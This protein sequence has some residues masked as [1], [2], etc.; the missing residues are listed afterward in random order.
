MDAERNVAVLDLVEITRRVCGID[1]YSSLVELL[2]ESNKKKRR[3]VFSETDDGRLLIRAAKEKDVVIPGAD[4][5]ASMVRDTKWNPVPLYDED[6]GRRSSQQV[7]GEFCEG[8]CR[9]E[10]CWKSLLRG[11]C[12]TATEFFLKMIF[13]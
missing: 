3:Y 6:D 11:S 8:L 10:H 9:E 4:F 13:L 2:K 12:W 5:K 1:S 7:G